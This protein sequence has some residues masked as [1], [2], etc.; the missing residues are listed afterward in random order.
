MRRRKEKLNHHDTRIFGIKINHLSSPHFFYSIF[1]RTKS[2]IEKLPKRKRKEKEKE[3]VL[4][5]RKKLIFTVLELYDKEITSPSLYLNLPD[6]HPKTHPGSNFTK[7]R[8][9][10]RISKSV[11][12]NCR[13]G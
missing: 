5:A 6:R 3:K 9:R 10:V 8:T 12:S 1:N 4:V 11:D 2:P 13:P 7:V